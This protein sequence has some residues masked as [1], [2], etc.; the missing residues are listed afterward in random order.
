[1]LIYDLECE[2]VFGEAVEELQ[3]RAFNEAAG[4]HR[5]GWHGPLPVVSWKAAEAALLFLVLKG[6][7]PDE[8][9]AAE[10]VCRE[11]EERI[12]GW[13]E[14]AGIPASSMDAAIVTCQ[15]IPRI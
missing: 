5:P 15:A 10:V 9:G 1:V 4:A 7:G 2:I 3:Q 12:R 8:P 14:E 11:A 13:A 6:P